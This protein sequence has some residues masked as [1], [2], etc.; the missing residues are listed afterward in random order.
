MKK[1]LITLIALNLILATL[2]LNQ[3][4][5]I[6]Y[7]NSQQHQ[8]NIIKSYLM[9]NYGVSSIDELIQKK[10]E[11]YGLHYTGNPFTTALYP[12]QLQAENITGMHWYTYLSGALQ[13]RTDVI[14]YPSQ[15]ARFIVENVSGT[16]VWKDGTNGTV[17]ETGTTSTEAA[18]LINWALGNLTSGRAWKEKVVL[19]GDFNVNSKI[20]IPNY[21]Y[22]DLS[23]ARLVL[24]VNETLLEV[25]SYCT[26]EGGELDGNRASYSGYGINI[27]GSQTVVKNVK[28]K[29]F[30]Y[31]GIIIDGGVN[32]RIE[33][34][35]VENCKHG[36]HLI[37]HASVNQLVNCQAVKND[38]RGFSIYEG[39]SNIID[40]C[41]G[42]RNGLFNF[43][44][45]GSSTY[46]SERN[47]ISNCIALGDSGSTGAQAGIAIHSYCH[48]NEV[49]GCLVA[50]NWDNGIE[51]YVSSGV[52]TTNHQ[53]IVIGN[54]CYKNGYAGIILRQARY[55]IVANNLCVSNGQR[56]TEP[57]TYPHR[58]SGISL[59]ADSGYESTR[60]KIINNKCF[61]DG[62]NTQYAGIYEAS[63][64]DRNYITENDVESNTDVA[65]YKT[66]ANSVVKRN[67]GFVTENS[68]TT[69]VANGEYIA[70]G[71]DSSLNIGQGN[72]SVL[73][74]EY[75]KVYDGVPV[76]VGCDYVNATHFRVAVYWTNGTAV[77]DDAIQIWW[78]VEYQP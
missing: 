69:T 68:G 33:N 32:N 34:C 16:I 49:V 67:I 58:A 43:L 71:I 1:I 11:E 28:V 2:T 39:R 35:Y 4:L 61:D 57:A 42:D 25:G 48:R 22:F 24:N 44:I 74:T 56:E 41:I 55:S 10:L 5:T 21:V 50:F 7:M 17:Y 12:G 66:G 31:W 27:T 78:K 46:T 40:G 9:A 38:E 37:N 76:T 63:N 54:I 6:T 20:I 62:A 47:V 3:F 19:K 18:N 30:E 36:F 51:I 29:D 15:P 14:A 13:N 70:H 64:C 23:S 60:N 65:I 77:T 52:A 75:T 8:N 53:N 73:I 59:V 26:I 45:Q 72:S